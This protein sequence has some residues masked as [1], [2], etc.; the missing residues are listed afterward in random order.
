MLKNIKNGTFFNLDKDDLMACMSHF[1]TYSHHSLLNPL[2]D[3]LAVALIHRNCSSHSLLVLLSSIVH[4]KVLFYL[5]YQQCLTELTSLSSL[6]HHLPLPAVYFLPY[7]LFIFILFSTSSSVLYSLE[8]PRVW[9]L[10]DL[11][12]K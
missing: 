3:V 10:L 7:Q 11:I 4:S 9:A 5:I 12:S 2:Q 8:C 6:K 1:S